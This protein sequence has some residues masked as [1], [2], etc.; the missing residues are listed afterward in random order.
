MMQGL[1]NVEVV[2]RFE[3]MKWLHLI[4]ESAFY[5]VVQLNLNQSNFFKIHFATNFV[6]IK[7][8]IG[9]NSSHCL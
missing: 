3:L 2:T 6:P 5:E 4:L 9:S 8:W 7:S 1:S